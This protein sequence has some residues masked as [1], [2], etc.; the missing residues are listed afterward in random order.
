MNHPWIREYQKNKVAKNFDLFKYVEND[1]CVSPTKE[2]QKNKDYHSPLFDSMAKEAKKNKNK[3]KSIEA[4]HSPPFKHTEL[5][6][7]MQIDK[8]T[9]QVKEIIKAS[10]KRYVMNKYTAPSPKV[11]LNSLEK[12]GVF[13]VDNNGIWELVSKCDTQQEAIDV[14]E[15]RA[16]EFDI[17][18]NKQTTIASTINKH[19]GTY[20]IFPIFEIK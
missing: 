17:E 12:R 7:C 10:Q 16:K 11:H 18:I 19:K 5:D 1:I 13:K 9:D 15:L 2:E 20:I 4:L 14:I 3:A 6:Q 8:K